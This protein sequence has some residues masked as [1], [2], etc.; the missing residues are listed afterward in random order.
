MLQDVDHSR[1]WH[2]MVIFWALLYTGLQ[3]VMVARSTIQVPADV[4]LVVTHHAVT[5]LVRGPGASQYLVR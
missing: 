3:A 5:A 1:T 2:I 4:L